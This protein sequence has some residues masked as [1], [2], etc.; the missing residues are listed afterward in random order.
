MIGAREFA[1]FAVD[2]LPAIALLTYLAGIL[3]GMILTR[4]IFFND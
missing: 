1:Y 2:L 4:R 3:T